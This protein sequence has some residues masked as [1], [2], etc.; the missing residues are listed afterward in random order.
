MFPDRKDW[1]LQTRYDFV[2][3]N[4]LA[5]WFTWK[6]TTSIFNAWILDRKFARQ[7]N[8]VT[9]CRKLETFQRKSVVDS[10]YSDACKREEPLDR[11]FWFKFLQ[12]WRVTN[13]MHCNCSIVY[14][15][16]F[17]E[18][19]SRPR[20]SG[21]FGVIFPCLSFAVWTSVS[22]GNKTL[23]YKQFSIV[24]LVAALLLLLLLFFRS[25]GRLAW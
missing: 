13:R 16:L 15:Q 11:P 3:S 6:I 9:V 4:M 19:S 17:S 2:L 25:L 21:S 24:I 10:H 12:G 18:R 5:K 8:I 22:L 20:L 23:R 1:W 14:A 7:R